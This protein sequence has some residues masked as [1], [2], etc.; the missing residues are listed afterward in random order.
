MSFVPS[1][2]LSGYD[3]QES[4]EHQLS[5]DEM[6]EVFD[7]FYSKSETTD[8][9]LN[10]YSRVLNEG[11][12]E[13]KKHERQF[14]KCLAGKYD[15]VLYSNGEVAFCEM[16][17][18]FTKIQDYDFDFFQAW[19]SPESNQMREK[20]SKC[21]CTH[22]CNLINAM[23]VNKDALMTVIYPNHNREG[24]ADQPRSIS[25]FQPIP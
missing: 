7:T 15:G 11:I 4:E 2:I 23:R 19:N 16:T 10:N 17:T 1:N 6:E 21:F 13:M 22:S 3:P 25:H 5:L 20:I 24:T 14:V 12:L 9:L 8:R 18:A